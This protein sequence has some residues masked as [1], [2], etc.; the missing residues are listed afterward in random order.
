VIKS[1]LCRYKARVEDVVIKSPLNGKERPVHVLAVL[2]QKGGVGKTSTCHH[3]AGTLGKMGRRVLLV[4][5][6][7]QASLTQGFL[8]PDAT[9]E[10]DPH[11]T[12]AAAYLGE[13]AELLSRP[14]G[15][16]GVDL[17][18]GSKVVHRFNMPE[19]AAEDWYRQSAI[20]R[21][22]EEACPR[23]R[24]TLYDYIIIDCPP[25]LCLCSWAALLAADHV[26]VPLQA[27]DYGAQGIADVLESVELVKSQ[28]RH[29]EVLGFLLT[30]FN[31]R[32][33]IHTFFE[34]TI[35]DLYGELVFKSFVPMAIDYKE[36]IAV[37]LP[38]AQHKPRSK[39]AKAIAAVA[40]ELESRLNV[41][42][43]LAQR[44]VA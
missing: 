33:A 32:F 30:M 9:R 42:S 22:C 6:D 19:P 25:N 39:A 29:L 44:G 5:N 24:D 40:E 11:D 36:S 27:E 12:V 21:L 3:L 16:L 43:T 10:L 14:T 8:G 26:L 17:V 34:Q 7:P 20:A 4:D 37:R 18:A 28:N 38:I 41:T 23:D 35:R 15:V 13:R 31:P 2:N 1:P